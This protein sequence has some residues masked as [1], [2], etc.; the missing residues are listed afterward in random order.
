MQ[1]LNR[2]KI[3]EAI[4]VYVADKPLLAR[5]LDIFEEENDD[6]SI[7]SA[8]TGSVHEVPYRNRQSKI[9]E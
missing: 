4:K 1:T 7:Y 6:M 8:F 2:N 9:K 3:S 5:G